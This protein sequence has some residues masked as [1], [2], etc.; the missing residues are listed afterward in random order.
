MVASLMA[1]ASQTIPNSFLGEWEEVWESILKEITSELNIEEQE[2]A[3][4]GE[5][6]VHSRKRLKRTKHFHVSLVPESVAR[7]L[8]LYREVL[9]LIQQGL[10]RI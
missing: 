5:R 2:L 10:L 1:R 9:I 6:E 3:R 7:V 8:F 4:Q